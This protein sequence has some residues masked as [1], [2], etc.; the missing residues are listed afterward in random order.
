L[1]P[2]L[3]FEKLLR[4]YLRSLKPQLILEWGTGNSTRMMLE[5]CPE[6][7]IHT[8]EHDPNWFI[9]WYKTF[10]ERKNVYAYCIP[11]TE[12][13]SLAPL[14]FMQK[15]KFDLIFIDGR[16]R[17]KCL[18]VA[19]TVMNDRGVVILHDSERE[20]YNDGKALFR[21]IEESDGTAVM[22]RS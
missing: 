22:T 12:N 8:I 17:V 2:F 18:Q 3:S 19:K 20:R 14:S 5:E 21:I 7:E 4:K 9:N 13:Y 11:L 16:H 10:R 1:A 15:G 6:S